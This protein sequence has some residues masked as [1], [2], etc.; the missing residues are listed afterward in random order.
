MKAQR[1]FSVTAAL[2]LVVAL[3]CNVVPD[4][5]VLQDLPEWML[6]GW[7]LRALWVGD[8][9]VAQA[10]VIAHAPVPNSASQLILGALNLVFSPIA[11]GKILI[12]VYLALG[13]VTAYCLAWHAPAAMRGAVRLLFV[14]SVVLG[15]GFWN[16][17]LNYQFGLLVVAAFLSW[18]FSRLT[19]SIG[20]TRGEATIVACV[21]GLAYF[22]HAIAFGGVLLVILAEL[23]C[24]RRQQ[25]LFSLAPASALTAWYLTWITSD[26]T[27][28][29]HWLIWLSSVS[30]AI[31]YKLYTAG[32]WGPFL[33]F[34]AG[35]GDSFLGDFPAVYWSGVGLNLVFGALVLLGLAL[36]APR[37]LRRL[38]ATTFVIAMVGVPFSCF[39]LLPFSVFLGI[40]NF[41]ERVLGVAL[42]SALVLLLRGELLQARLVNG[43][44]LVTLVC[45]PVVLVC[46]LSLSPSVADPSLRGAPLGYYGPQRY[47]SSRPYQFYDTARLLRAGPNSATIPSLR[48]QTSLLQN[49]L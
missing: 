32:K 29:G 37:F 2:L 9:L 8:P 40:A 48:F 7:L 19:N 4:I 25:L 34:Y 35:P 17:Y 24:T 31:Q 20:P 49:R 43:L 1:I 45:A 30:E 14:S 27:P 47:Y 12:T 44:A 5:P 11:A 38:P 36:G 42:V 16:G 28:V 10:V 18:R 15:S 22:V 3:L 13:A 46:A 21:V 6:Q 23:W 41:G 33:N 26:A 39:A